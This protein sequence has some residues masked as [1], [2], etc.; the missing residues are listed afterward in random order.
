MSGSAEVV[1]SSTSEQGP[2]RRRAPPP[3]LPPPRP[4]LH[5]LSSL[6]FF[7]GMSP[8]ERIKRA[9]GP[10]LWAKVIGPQ[11]DAQ[12]ESLLC[13]GA[14]SRLPRLL[15]SSFCRTHPPP[16]AP[17]CGDKTGRKCSS[18]LLKLGTRAPSSCQPSS[19]GPKKKKGSYY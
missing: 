18:G 14:S 8:S 15:S 5:M 7:L 17:L 10:E 13:L 4:A 3:R 12:A 11:T 6:Y 16:P 19:P 9:G 1:A 2:R